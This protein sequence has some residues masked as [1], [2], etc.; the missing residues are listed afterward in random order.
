MRA[1]ANSY[2]SYE[3]IKYRV[4]MSLK[5]ACEIMIACLIA[6]AIFALIASRYLV[7]EPYWELSWKYPIAKVANSLFLYPSFIFHTD[8][9][10]SVYTAAYV[11][12]L[13]SGSVYG[14]IVAGKWYLSFL[15][16]CSA[17]VFS[18]P[19]YRYF[20]SNSKNIKNDEHIRGARLIAESE[21]S[22]QTDGT[23]ILPMGKILIPES[24][25][26]RHIFIG[27]QTGSGKSTVLI[28]HVDAIQ[29]AQRRA[30]VN[31]FKGELVERFYRPERD[32]ILNPLDSRGLGWTIF[33][34][35]KNKPDLGAIAGSLIPAATGEDRF[36]VSAAQ[37]VL[38]GVMA[39]C[40]N[41]GQR[42][43]AA[44]WKAI[45][46]PT[47]DLAKMCQ[48]TSSGQ[49]GFSYLQDHSS[50]LASGVVAVLMSYAGWL[51]FA[52][53]GPFSLREWAGNSD[54]NI[55]YITTLD[56]LANTLCPY[57]SLFA[58]LAG[59]RLLALPEQPEDNRTIYFIL[60]ELGNMQ[61][62]PTVKRL[63]TAGRSKGVVVE[64]GVQ[65]LA[66]I[67]SVYDREDCRTIVNNCGSKMIMN[68][69]DPDTAKFFSELAGE[70][71]FW[72]AATSY[73]IGQDSERGGEKHNRQVQT[74]K[75][76]LPAEIMRL[77]VGQGYFMLPGGNPALISVPWTAANKRPSIHKPFLLRQ[78]LSMD[79]AEA[80]EYEIN[81]RASDVRATPAPEE[82]KDKVLG[83]S[84]NRSR[85]EIE[86][87]GRSG[88][89]LNS[90]MTL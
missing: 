44:L 28:Q 57:I 68:L 5:M 70:E 45:T 22:L 20:Y 41:T 50:K 27:G 19:L 85:E 88:S 6:Q 52:S 67:E 2:Q 26:R 37:D 43:N 24:L 78:G 87:K 4:L 79:Y 18:I 74:R 48:Q 72:Q 66:G 16:S 54:D 82:L 71:E 53:D 86:R 25:S 89:D 17:W 11:A 46:S 30:L 84:V 62:L 51:E 80:R 29:R 32:L 14:G 9:N 83:N 21:I 75:V 47:A 55:I 56:E 64:I 35:L 76:V 15:L 23:G 42:S 31:D 38:R 3:V 39:Y 10:A 69:G 7:P 58:D 13:D 33:N 8:G 81:A 90:S 36:W 59:K 1:S 60:D 40:H 61:K 49:A 63:L 65:D 73:N 12:S 77:A 34:E